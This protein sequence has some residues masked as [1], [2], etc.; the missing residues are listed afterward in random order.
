MLA[1]YIWKS[2]HETWSPFHNVKEMHS[3]RLP[4]K[5]LFLMLS[6]TAY[7]LI[8]NCPT[9]MLSQQ[10][11]LTIWLLRLLVLMYILIFMFQSIWIYVY[12]LKHHGENTAKLRYHQ[13]RVTNQDNYKP[14]YKHSWFCPELIIRLEYFLRYQF[15]W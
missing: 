2:L 15:F 10:C 1:L 7:F 5:K 11:V 13:S 12:V 8:N 4:W 3:L 14:L 9:S 6:K